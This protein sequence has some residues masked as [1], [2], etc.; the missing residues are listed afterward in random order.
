MCGWLFLSVHGLCTVYA[1]LGT[2][3][4]LHHGHGLVQSI[5]HARCGSGLEL[6]IVVKYGIICLTPPNISYPVKKV[7]K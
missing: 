3:V 5:G 4:G 7:R 1:C 2:D 6:A